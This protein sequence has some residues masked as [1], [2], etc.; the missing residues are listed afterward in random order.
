L[1]DLKKRFETSLELF[2]SIPSSYETSSPI[3]LLETFITR[4]HQREV[5]EGQVRRHLY[6]LVSQLDEKAHGPSPIAYK[7]V[8]ANSAAPH[9]AGKVSN[10]VIDQIVHCRCGSM[11]DETSLVQC[12]AC[13]VRNTILARQI[14]RICCLALATCRM[15]FN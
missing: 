2:Q 5:I 15:R 1:E 9:R 6:E 4:L 12:Y 10:S 11:Q 13:Q 3:N 8:L 14:R 7:I